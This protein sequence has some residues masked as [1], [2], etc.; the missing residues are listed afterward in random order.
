MEIIHRVLGRTIDL[1]YDEDEQERRTTDQDDQ[2]LID[3][4]M[5]IPMI[6]EEDDRTT[7]SPRGPDI[8]RA[9]IEPPEDEDDQDR[10][11]E[12]DDE[13]GIGHINEYERTIDSMG[14]TVDIDMSNDPLYRHYLMGISKEDILNVRGTHIDVKT[15]VFAKNEPLSQTKSKEDEDKSIH[16][17]C[18]QMLDDEE[19]MPKEIRAITQLYH[20]RARFRHRLPMAPTYHQHGEVPTFPK[21]DK[22][23]R[24]EPVSQSM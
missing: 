19:N 3:E 2:T 21:E 20:Q 13:D 17:F 23:P 12:E 10:G 11:E 6:L 8:S 9:D 18:I 14:S 16:H 4:A 24:R 15:P 22:T 1:V 5:K 7:I